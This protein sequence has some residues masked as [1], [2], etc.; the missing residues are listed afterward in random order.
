MYQAIPVGDIL[1]NKIGMIWGVN[2]DKPNTGELMLVNQ[3]YPNPFSGISNVLVWMSAP[4]DIKL[5][6]RNTAGM[7][8]RNS[9]F[10]GMNRGNHILS[11]D[12][13]GLSS[14][15]YTYSLISGGSKVSRTMM[16][17]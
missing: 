6:V 11:I 5:E 10:N 17:H 2:V 1:N 16:V 9:T 7:L 12:A 4:G 13:T 8:V 14:G 3:N 15:V